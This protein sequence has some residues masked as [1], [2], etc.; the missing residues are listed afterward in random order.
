MVSAQAIP[1]T[2]STPTVVKASLPSVTYR[3]PAVV[4]ASGAT[5]LSAAQPAVVPD[6]APMM[7]AYKMQTAAQEVWACRLGAVMPNFYC[8]TTHGDF[9]FHEFL[10]SDSPYTILMTHP[11]DFTPVCTTELGRAEVIAATLKERGVKLIALSCDSVDDHLEWSRDIL[12]VQNIEKADGQFMSYPMIADPR[13]ELVTMLGML[14][15]AEKDAEGLPLPARAL[16]VIGPDKTVKLSILYP[17]TTGRNF[18]EVL[19]VIDSLQLTAEMSL[20]TPV[21]WKLGERCMVSPVVSTEDAQ[22]KF[23][24]FAIDPVPSGKQ[25][26]RSVDC[27]TFG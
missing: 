6:P 20:A 14:D 3:A 16:V 7:T 1:T 12:A 13:K 25:Y 4:S 17:A 2:T 26:L 23:P 8:S 5:V 19:R 15:P 21:D 27:P 18:E 22:W 9:Y 24:G 10:D 11:K